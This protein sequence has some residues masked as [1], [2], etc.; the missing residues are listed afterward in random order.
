MKLEFLGW[1]PDVDVCGEA[2]G[3]G[4]GDRLLD[5]VVTHAAN[6]TFFWEVVDDVAVI[7]AGVARSSSAARHAAYIAARRALI[8]VV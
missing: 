8:R 5:L 1:E 2:A 6:C 3:L 7:A 4:L